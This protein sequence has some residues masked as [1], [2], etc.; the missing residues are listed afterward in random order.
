V[1]TERLA[2]RQTGASWQLQQLAAAP[3]LTPDALARMLER[4]MQYS[5]S[6]LPIAQWPG[7]AI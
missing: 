4:Y 5:Q 1:I 7:A 6:N 3:E 2:R